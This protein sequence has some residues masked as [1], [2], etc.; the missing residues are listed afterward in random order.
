MIEMN[1]KKTQL[2]GCLC[3]T[4]RNLKKINADEDKSYIEES[5]DFFSKLHPGSV[6]YDGTDEYPNIKKLMQNEGDLVIWCDHPFGED[7]IFLD[8]KY[9]GYADDWSTMIKFCEDSGMN[10]K[11]S[12]DVHRYYL[13]NAYD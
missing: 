5:K 3:C 6:G 11:N 13:D 4:K 10:F 1:G 12:K 7:V 2:L 8:E 9:Y